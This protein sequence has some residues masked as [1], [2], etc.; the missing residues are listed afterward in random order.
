M[1]QLIL[2]LGL[3]ALG[4][5]SADQKAGSGLSGAKIITANDFESTAG[6]NVDPG[7]LDRGR[8]H[9]G[10]YAIKVDQGHEFSLTFDM[11]L[12]QA[13]PTKIKVVNLEAWAFLP[14]ERATG[15][16]G[17]QIMDSGT[18]QQVFGDGIRLGEVVKSY[19]EWVHISKDITLPDNITAIQHIRLSLW[20]ADASDYVLVD[21][22]KLS[23][24]E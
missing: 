9:S 22:V 11:V 15:M 6:W 7:Y 1:K 12:G 5:C 4:A 8:A 21:D 20:R 18:G 14:S 10:Q 23:V 17:I 24:K 16:L 19:G 3:M 2:L 13:T